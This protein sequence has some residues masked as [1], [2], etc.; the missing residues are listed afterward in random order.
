MSD[1]VM[2]TAEVAAALKLS[3]SYFRK[4]RRKLPGFPQP[5]PGGRTWA[6]AQVEAWLAETSG[7]STALPTETDETA[8][9]DRRRERRE[10]AKHL[11]MGGAA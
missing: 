10:R 6:R 2:T 9:A 4:R 1:L 5:L 7:D 8:A 11:A 3:T